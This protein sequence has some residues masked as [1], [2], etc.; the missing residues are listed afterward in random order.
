[1]CSKISWI[2]FRDGCFEKIDLIESI[3]IS[4]CPKY[5]LIE[6]F[7]TCYLS[8]PRN[9]LEP[10]RTLETNPRNWAKILIINNTIDADKSRKVIGV[11]K[12]YLNFVDRIKFFETTH[13]KKFLQSCWLLWV[14]D[15]KLIEGACPNGID[16]FSLP[17]YTREIPIFHFI[18]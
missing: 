8:K 10:A 1:M 16:Y 4:K 5:L 13:E 18:Y 3:N 12:Y 7:C 2:E 9:G 6:H 11:K 17:I 15:E 14:R